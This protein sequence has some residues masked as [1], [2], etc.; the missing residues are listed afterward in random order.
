MHFEPSYNLTGV[1]LGNTEA[2]A[3]LL[4]REPLLVLRGCGVLLCGEKL[5]Q[6]CL[7]VRIR[8]KYQHHAFEARVRRDSARVVFPSRQRVNVGWT[9]H[10]ETVVDRGDDT[11]GGVNRAL[12]R[13]RDG[14]NEQT[15]NEAEEESEGP[16]YFHVLE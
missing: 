6:G 16:A 14:S 7:L 12:C 10:G 4:G 15:C 11:V 1:A 2:G 13:D 9:G 3:K 8:R 5:V